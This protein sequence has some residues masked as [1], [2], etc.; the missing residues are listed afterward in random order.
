VNSTDSSGSTPLM[1]AANCD[2]QV[3][4]IW[5]LFY[6]DQKK[7]FEFY[8]EVVESLV[9]KHG[10]DVRLI[11]KEGHCVLDFEDLSFPIKQILLLSTWL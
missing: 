4:L 5:I 8:Q 2:Y 11:N 3:H 6:F 7:C 10:A 1:Y 9:V